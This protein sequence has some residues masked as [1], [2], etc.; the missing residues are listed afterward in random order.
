MYSNSY[1]YSIFALIV[2]NYQCVLFCFCFVLFYRFLI[3]I[4]I[5]HLLHLCDMLKS[6]AGHTFVLQKMEGRRKGPFWQFFLAK[7]DLDQTSA[8][9]RKKT[10]ICID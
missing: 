9:Q 5:D 3:I 10:Y 6:G 7:S 2:V 1:L 4:K 8:K